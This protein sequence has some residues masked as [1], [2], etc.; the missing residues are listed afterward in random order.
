LVTGP[1]GSGKSTTLYAALQEISTR[2]RNVVTLED[3]IE[4]QIEGISQTQINTKKGLTFAAGLR[5]ILRQ[6]PD[7]IMVGEIRDHETAELAIQSALTGHLVF[8]TLHTNDA[9]SAV[10]RLL[11]LGIEPYLVSSSLL[12]VLAQRL[13]RRIC[14]E[15]AEARLL[16]PEEVEFLNANGVEQL[17]TE[18]H[19]GV[20]CEHCRETGL[21]GRVGIYEL[22]AIND[23]V[24]RRIQ[25]R[26]NASEIRHAALSHGMRLLR[27]DGIEKIRTGVT[28]VEEV[29]RV[30]MRATM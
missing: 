12:A 24:R 9:A 17:P 22:L 20:G 18:L 26:D 14:G 13:V 7:I 30:T 29:S 8:S 4:Y 23:D 28:T 2:D 19:T 27:E 5:S 6:D 10:T 3:P 1:T 25:Q 15:C 11:D 16:R 21:R